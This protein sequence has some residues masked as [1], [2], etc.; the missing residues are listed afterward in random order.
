MYRKRRE[1][2]HEEDE[3]DNEEEEKNDEVRRRNVSRGKGGGLGGRREVREGREIQNGRRECP[4]PHPVFG[5][6]SSRPLPG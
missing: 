6:S 2:E 1:V 4:W 3:E 5:L